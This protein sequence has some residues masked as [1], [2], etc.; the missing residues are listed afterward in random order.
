MQTRSLTKNE[1]PIYTAIKFYHTCT[2]ICIYR[3]LDE[4]KGMAKSRSTKAHEKKMA[5]SSGEGAG[6]RR[7]NPIKNI[8]ER[9]TKA[10]SQLKKA[11]P[12]KKPPCGTEWH[13]LNYD[14][15]DYSKNFDDGEWRH[16]EAVFYGTRSFSSRYVEPKV[17]G[18]RH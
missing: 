9:V 8:F 11:A 10:L 18:I 3:Q 16:E 13:R 2:H 7:R 15:F 17:I 6:Y 14:E 5:Q 12:P 4:H 1:F